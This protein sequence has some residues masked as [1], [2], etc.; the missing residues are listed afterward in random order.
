MIAA[1]RV[2]EKRLR[3]IGDPFDRTADLPRRPQADHFLG[4]DENLRAEGAADIGRDHAQLVFGRNA[5]E[6]GEHQA[7]DVRVLTCRVERVTARAAIILADRRARLDGVWDQTIV[8]DLELGDMACLGESG[9]DRGLVTEMPLKDRVVRRI[10]VDLRLAGLL[11]RGEIDDG[12]EHIVIDVD[13]FGCVV[14]LI[15]RFGDDD[16]NMIA[17]IAHLIERERGMRTRLHG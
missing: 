2:G 7:R 1:V 14:S 3:A 13:E 8:G 6:R 9:I 5:D 10:C 17:D 16:R 12:V 11:R 15:E 4:I